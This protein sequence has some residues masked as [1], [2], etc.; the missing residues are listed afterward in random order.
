MGLILGGIFVAIVY[1]IIRRYEKNWWVLGTLASVA[2]FAFTTLITPVFI[3]PLFNKFTPLEKGEVREQILSMARSNGVPADEVFQFDASKQS[4]R[5]SANVSGLWGTMRIS[6]N[7]NLLNKTSLPEIRAVMGHEIG[8]FALNHVFKFIMEFGLVLL[9]GFY[10]VAK[11][12]AVFVELFSEKYQLRGVSDLA[13][14]PVLMALLSV[15]MFLVT[16]LT[17]TIVRA[18][19]TEADIY[20]LN[21]SREPDGFAK[22]ALKLSEY[23]KMSPGYW[24]EIMFYD[25]PSGEA[26]IRMAM[27]WKIENMDYERPKK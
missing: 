11:S 22:I 8:H 17:N 5:V 3:A 19:E 25:H 27:K 4:D 21:L 13:G 15:F 23:R 10:F 18:G 26:R 24:E 12:L 16:P 20:G 2:F 1:K 6:L 7:D 14:F 9:F